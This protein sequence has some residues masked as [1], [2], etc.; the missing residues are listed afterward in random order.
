MGSRDLRFKVGTGDSTSCANGMLRGRG[1]WSEV[2]E[3]SGWDFLSRRRAWPGLGPGAG[4][5]HQRLG[6]G[7][8]GGG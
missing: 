8:G 6:A 2:T 4:H 7:A 5:P 1:V 3:E